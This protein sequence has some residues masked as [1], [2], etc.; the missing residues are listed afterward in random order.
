MTSPVVKLP[1]L[2]AEGFVAIKLFAISKRPDT[3]VIKLDGVSMFSDSKSSINT[4]ADE[5]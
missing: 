3:A 1:T 5:L 2:A 4:S